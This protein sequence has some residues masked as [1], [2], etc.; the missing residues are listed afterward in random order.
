[1]ASGVGSGTI[2]KQKLDRIK[3]FLR[4]RPANEG[5]HASAVTNC[6]PREINVKGH[7]KGYSFDQIFDEKTTQ[8]KVYKT[9]VGNMIQDVVK[10]YNCTVFAY[11]QTGTGKTFTI[12]GG[13]TMK[14]DSG[15][16]HWQQDS[17]AGIVLRAAMHLYEVLDKMDS[18]IKRTVTVSFM[19]I[20]NE[21]IKDL[22]S[23]KE[24]LPLRL[25]E[26]KAKVV[27]VKNLQEV[28]VLNPWEIF[29]L[30]K[31]GCERRHVSSTLMN[32]RS[33][34]SHTVF[35]INVN[36]IQTVSVAENLSNITCGKLN[37]ID[38]AGSENLAKSGSK[39]QRAREATSIN[40]SL[41]TL[42]RVIKALVE[43]SSHIPYRESKLT[44]I[45][46][47]SLGG[48]TKTTI[49]ATIS[50]STASLDETVN[51]LEYAHN[52][53]NV[54]NCPVI[55][56]RTSDTAA[57]VNE[58]LLRLKRD[59][60][61]TANEQG[62]YMDKENYEEMTQSLTQFKQDILKKHETIRTLTQQL[63]DL[64]S[65]KDEW[66]KLRESFETT[67][68]AYDEC[69]SEIQIK[70][71]QIQEDNMLLLHYENESV[72]FRE[73]LD[74][75]TQRDSHLRKK[76]D[77]I[78]TSSRKNQ[79]ALE[80]IISVV[81]NIMD[82]L[83]KQV[84]QNSTVV[85]EKI[86]RLVD[87]NGKICHMMKNVSDQLES[88]S[89]RVKNYLQNTVEQCIEVCTNALEELG[90][91][92]DIIKKNIHDIE[93][94]SRKTK[95]HLLDEVSK[96]E[97]QTKEL[98][99]EDDNNY[100]KF[101]NNLT[102]K[103]DEQKQSLVEYLQKEYDECSSDI[104]H[105]EKKKIHLLERKVRLAEMI[106]KLKDWEFQEEISKYE[107]ESKTAKG[108]IC[109]F[110]TVQEVV[111]QQSDFIHE[112]ILKLSE[113]EGLNESISVL[114]NNHSELGMALENIED[115]SA[116]DKS[117]MAR[118]LGQIIDIFEVESKMHIGQLEDVIDSSLEYFNTHGLK[119]KENVQ[120]IF[121][122]DVVQIA[123][124]GDTPQRL[125]VPVLR[126]HRNR[127]SL[128]R[129]L[130]TDI[131]ETEEKLNKDNKD[132]S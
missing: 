112:K 61:A 40:Q 87:F 23:D 83:E 110:S 28:T 21:E 93:V 60:F 50:P 10:G 90:N 131:P 41:L 29:A 53:R 1:M 132:T 37:L 125:Q 117:E 101:A 100:K 27:H 116:T 2:K 106:E 44:R 49:I 46:Q 89:S 88:P 82:N 62:I 75:M 121:K 47:D 51:T 64:E 118:V 34:R 102:V 124:K 43:N 12:L 94:T 52:A 11:G 97:T 3:V 78:Y 81:E 120:H 77:N 6:T 19:E 114:Q 39:D 31:K 123:P 127:D 13:D 107:K 79:D 25:Y 70:R 103:V 36:T 129:R 55:N 32:N 96:K 80:T 105:L 45:L 7:S 5:E 119:A 130:T 74:L 20:Y 115:H 54:T 9:V 33:S 122:T 73:Y 38:L 30:L 15:D 63:D 113:N 91:K 111:S 58:E 126:P 57:A 8:L 68:R 128:V 18:N 48:K 67:R 14:F 76:L 42:G 22:L 66:E 59:L 85:A 65:Q 86:S 71:G 56:L 99:D 84:N 35:T 72:K 17:D 26:D 4:V 92:A 98:C 108:K 69:Q 109:D 95:N 104:E 24:V 16:F